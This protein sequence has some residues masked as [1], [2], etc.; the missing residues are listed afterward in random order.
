MSSS[1][2]RSEA[3]TGTPTRAS[4][5]AARRVP[6]PRFS[7]RYM[8]RSVDPSSDFYGYATGTW[9]RENP[10]PPDKSRWG[11]F[12]E[13]LQRNFEILRSILDEARAHAEEAAATPRRQVGALYASAIDTATRDRRRFEPIRSD[14]ERISGVGTVDDLALR[15]ATLHREGVGGW[16]FPYVYPDKR[17]SD[18]YAF[19]LHQGGLSLPD[20]EYYLEPRFEAIR[21]AYRAHL[22][23]SFVALRDAVGPARAATDAVLAIEVE[24]ARASRPR[25]DLREQ[26]KNYHRFSASELADRHRSIK[27]ARY[28][29]GRGLGKAPYLV[30]G[31]PEFFDAL[32]E[33]IARH[34]LGEWRDYL[35]WQVVRDGAPYL[36]AEAEAE[37]FDFFHR[38]LRG[39]REPEPLWKRAALAVDALLGEALGELYVAR[40]FSPE[41]RA[42]MAVLVDDLRAVFRD[43]LR[44]LPWMSEKTR[45]RALAKFARFSAK[46][47]HP[48]RYRDYSSVR[49][50]PTDHLGNVRRAQAFEIHR[51][52]ARV[53]GPVD[54]TEWEMTPP[55]VNAYFSPVFNEIVFPAG[56]LQPPFFDV[57]ADDAVNYGG[58]G[59]VIGHEITHGYDDQGRKFDEHGNLADWW[60]AA[61]AREFQRRADAVAGQYER[62]EPLPGQR[63]N[64]RLTLGE[65]VADLGGLSIAFEA[66]QRRLAAEP[67]R[68]RTIDGLTAEQR[69]FV[70]WAQVWRQNAPDEEVRRRLVTDTH[71]PGR[72]RAIGAAGNLDAFY[73][74]FAIGTGRPMWRPKGERVSIW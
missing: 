31:Q 30:V 44:A 14:L 58:I 17:A 21:A 9:L 4:A 11:A 34:P 55:T 38:T 33:C 59:A 16:F 49:I 71:S 65:N 53:G 70:S 40:A 12:D 52:V 47:G 36:H 18:V 48:T 37:S 15:V 43:R 74:A 32:D 23:R 27:W 24:L 56:I 54:R 72:F 45:A 50:D 68:R 60:T 25:A 61:D 8:D 19:Y 51:E 22:E 28:L 10:V 2:R 63:V 66:L 57:A 73:D 46:I 62:Y 67:S 26:E 20:R 5:V 13:L 1:K 64:G 7:V 41:S 39:Q 3:T 69:F 35:R 6:D 42:R 29:R